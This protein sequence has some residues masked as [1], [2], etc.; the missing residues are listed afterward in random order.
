MTVFCQLLYFE[1]AFHT[2]NDPDLFQQTSLTLD[3]VL[4]TSQLAFLK[5]KQ[6]QYKWGG[7]QQA[8]LLTLWI[9]LLEVQETMG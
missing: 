8:S 9:R 6:N 7:C 1:G 2:Q 4:I 5:A 3:Q